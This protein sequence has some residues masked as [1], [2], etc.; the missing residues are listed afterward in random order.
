MYYF[1]MLCITEKCADNTVRLSGSLKK[2][3]GCVEVCVETMWTSRCD[4]SWDFTEAQVVCRELGYSPYGVTNMTV[5][6]V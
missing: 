2:Y 5:C 4:E 6:S 3:S 1:M